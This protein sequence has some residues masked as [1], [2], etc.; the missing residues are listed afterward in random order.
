MNSFIIYGLEKR[1]LATH[2]DTWLCEL[3][4]Q[5]HQALSDS[6][7]AK[8]TCDYMDTLVGLDRRE[9]VVYG[10]AT[11]ESSVCSLKKMT[12]GATQQVSVDSV[13]ITDIWKV[14]V[15]K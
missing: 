1:C 4:H 11:S 6:L 5:S 10:V 3:T 7:E 9:C 13:C 8:H 14:N 12:I 15:I 2:E